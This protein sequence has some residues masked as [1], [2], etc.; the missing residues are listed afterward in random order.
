MPDL[1]LRTLKNARKDIDPHGSALNEIELLRLKSSP[2]SFQSQSRR[3]YCG[4]SQECE[5]RVEAKSAILVLFHRGVIK[6]LPPQPT[7]KKVNS[8]FNIESTPEKIYA[9]QAAHLVAMY[10]QRLKLVRFEELLRY[11]AVL[12]P[13]T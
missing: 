6:S 11:S 8:S 12:V 2:D 7:K 5:Q 13:L 9:Q 1:V 3:G 10:A 4:P